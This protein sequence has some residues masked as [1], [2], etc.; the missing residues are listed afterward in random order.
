[1]NAQELWSEVVLYWPSEIDI[2]DSHL[3]HNTN[4][5]KSQNLI[6]AWNT[7]EQNSLG[8]DWHELGIW[9]TYKLLHRLAKV[10]FDLKKKTILIV[11]IEVEEF[12]K[13]LLDALQ[14]EG[15]EDMLEQY[16]LNN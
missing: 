9:I 3:L 12:K 10:N 11:Q 2:S 4:G 15:Y 8:N 7:A 1:M 13:E 16:N 14:T 5:L 6:D